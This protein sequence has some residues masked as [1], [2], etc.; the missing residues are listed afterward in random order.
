MNYNKKYTPK[1]TK[2]NKSFNLPKSN[3]ALSAVASTLL[4]SMPVMAQTA[5]TPKSA[6]S[7]KIET[8]VVTAQFREQNLQ[9]T[10]L[11][12]TATTGE[13]ME[14]R[15]QNNIIDVANR[16]PSVTI[17]A[18]GASG[19]AQSVTAN[20]RGI[21]QADF[22]MASEPGVGMYIDDV[23]H[24]VMFGS[25]FELLDLERVEVLRGPQG[26]LSGKNSAGGSIKLFSKQPDD[27]PGGYFQATVGSY[28]RMDIRAGVNFEVIP[29]KLYTRITALNK[30]RE[31]FVKRYDY[32]CRNGVAPAPVSAGSISLSA[33]N[34]EI[35]REGGHDI[36]ALRAAFLY[37]ISDTITN[38]LTFDFMS[39]E[40]DP[41]ASLLVH[42][43]SWHGPNF[44]LT[45]NIPNTPQNFVTPDGKYYNYAN[46]TALIGTDSQYTYA[47]ISNVENWGISNVFKM[48]INANLSLTS[49]T[50]WRE[51]NSASNSDDDSSPLSRLTQYWEV[52]YRQFTQEFRLNGRIDELADWT[53]GA[54]YYDSDSI[55]GGRVN[56]DGAV[57]NAIPFYVPVDFVTD[58]P[59]TTTSKSVFAHASFHITDNLNITAGLRYTEDEKEYGFV[60]EYAQGVAQNINTLIT[61]TI[62]PLDGEVGAFKGDQLDWRLAVD[63]KVDEDINVYA[64]ASTGFKGGGVNPRPYYAEQ[65]L[66]FTP[67]EVTAYEVGLKSD[68]LDQTLRINLA[69][70]YNDF[71]DLQLK[72]LNCPQYV[73]AGAPQNCA[74]TTN[75]GDATITGIELEID[76]RPLDDMILDAAISY[77]NFEY[78][79]IDPSA[80]IS[81][82]MK[83]QFTPE[84]KIALGAQYLF[85]FQESGS[86]TPRI[87]YVYQSEVFS[88]A[89]NTEN[90]KV[91]SYG[92]SNA[93]V[94][95]RTQD[96]D[97]ELAFAVTN[98]FDKYY[99]LNYNDR[100]LPTVSTYQMTSGQPGRPREVS[101]SLKYNFE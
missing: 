83:P 82:D 84:W 69:A 66:A 30:H 72:L 87:D 57:D 37:K 77:T 59:V 99:F 54:Y 51:L 91:D 41:S 48:D 86:L 78:D 64:Q 26:T 76:A 38:N 56:L 58:D 74:M 25:T 19:G 36:T 29:N 12:I 60:R 22:N 62:T 21:G 31:G 101:L 52:D 79:R 13:M 46:Y 34:C 92:I 88:N 67:E 20:I 32:Q 50:A 98:L 33:N 18:G 95:Y 63:F 40:S 70:F 6:H 47:A 14:S 9:E 2:I 97:W 49:I 7:N 4:A 5:D 93:R 45:Q 35:G 39:D 81:L 11:A 71:T 55:Q 16:A 68:L 3:F 85:D 89:I 75:V 80:G 100:S 90:S 24:G 73:P 43:G 8:I 23:Y 96:E 65:V 94:T 10:P 27:D 17:I 44:D 61:D 15:S 53:L 1:N 42:Q 28:K